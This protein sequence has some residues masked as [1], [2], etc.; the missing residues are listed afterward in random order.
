[1]KYI[2]YFSFSAGFV[3]LVT[4]AIMVASEVNISDRKLE[5][6]EV[7]QG[8]AMED[9]TMLINYEERIPE[10]V[11]ELAK[12]KSDQLDHDTAN[13]MLV[14]S[15]CIVASLHSYMYCLRLKEGDKGCNSIGI[16]LP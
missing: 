5:T 9:T 8:Y 12:L 3:L 4:A 13:K 16:R 15:E 1:M 7:F 10:M 2:V 6:L 14:L 11:E